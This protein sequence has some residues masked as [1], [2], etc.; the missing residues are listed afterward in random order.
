M[1]L[2]VKPNFPLVILSQLSKI[3]PVIQ[4][5]FFLRIQEYNFEQNKPNTYFHG[6]Y[7]LVLER[8]TGNSIAVKCV[9]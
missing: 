2:F 8:Q 7:S 1:C 3:C 5:V 4:K 9:K 6:A